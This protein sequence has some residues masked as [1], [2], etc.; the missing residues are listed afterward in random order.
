MKIARENNVEL[1]LSNYERF[2]NK[3]RDKNLS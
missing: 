1:F 3:I 2:S